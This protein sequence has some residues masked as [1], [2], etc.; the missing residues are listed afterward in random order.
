MNS[1]FSTKNI[2]KIFSDFFKPARGFPTGS[3]LSFLTFQ[4]TCF[5]SKAGAKIWSIFTKT[6][7]INFF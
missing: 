7:Y 6:N 4:R 1:S 2:L 5:L 3:F